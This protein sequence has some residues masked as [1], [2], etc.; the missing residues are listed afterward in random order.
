MTD[1]ITLKEALEL[2]EFER[3][4]AGWRV[5][6]VFGD[7]SDSVCGNVGGSVRGDVWG[8][9]RGDVWGSVRGDVRGNVQGSVGGTIKGRRWGFVETPREKLKRLI[10][11]GAGKDELLAA[12][13]Q[14]EDSDG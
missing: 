13:D 11:E 12:I 3:V 4:P 10:E 1:Q 7:V 14:L 9:V 6:N 5:K 8:S 2:V